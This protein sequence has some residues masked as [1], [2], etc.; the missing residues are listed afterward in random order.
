MA[1]KNI[2]ISTQKMQS[3][4]QYASQTALLL[5][6]MNAWACQIAKNGATFQ[7]KQWSNQNPVTQ[8]LNSESFNCFIPKITT[9][10]GEPWNYRKKNAHQ[11]KKISK[12]KLKSMFLGRRKNIKQLKGI[13][14]ESS[15]N[16]NSKKNNYT[17]SIWILNNQIKKRKSVKPNR[18]L[19][20]NN[21]R[22][23]NIQLLLRFTQTRENQEP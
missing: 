5:Q 4:W 21:T 8:N 6:T 7:I 18:S 3:I 9:N 1:T 17:S 2:K 11:F 16:N 14:S 22:E 20:I 13:R 10:S 12:F 23:E 19:R 15:R